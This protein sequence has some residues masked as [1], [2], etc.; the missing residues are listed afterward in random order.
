MIKKIG[1]GFL[2]FVAIYIVTLIVCGMVVGGIAGANDPANGYAAG[3]AA[4]QAFGEKY[5]GLVLL[6]SAL[7]AIVGS[8]LGWLPGT[9]SK[10]TTA[11]E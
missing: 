3:Q 10:V 6:L 9:K 7:A 1:F 4:G 11:D 5:G 8:A 2:W